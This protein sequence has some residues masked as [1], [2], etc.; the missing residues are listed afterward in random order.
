MTMAGP[1]R[2]VAGPPAAA[3]STTTRTSTKSG[4]SGWNSSTPADGCPGREVGHGQRLELE[5]LEQ[6][7]HVDV[8]RREP[9]AQHVVAR[10]HQLDA[11]PLQVGVDVAGRQDRAPRRAASVTRFSSSES[12][13]PG[14]PGYSSASVAHGRER[15]A[16]TRSLGE[17]ARRARVTCST[18]AV[19]LARGPPQ[20]P[21]DSSAVE[22]PRRAA[23]AREAATRAAN[24]SGA[25]A[26]ERSSAARSSGDD[27]RGSRASGRKPQSASKRLAQREMTSGLC[28]ASL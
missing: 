27:R 12:T 25:A 18:S 9:A 24:G 21:L 4:T 7:G 15:R 14:S 28:S 3:S 6:L 2:P 26:S 20:Q 22:R 10:R 1:E 8:L 16:R 13:M 19:D 11:E 23:V 17:P 5:H